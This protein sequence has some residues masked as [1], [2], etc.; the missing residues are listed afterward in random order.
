MCTINSSIQYAND[1][2]F[3]YVVVIFYM[4]YLTVRLHLIYVEV[5][6]DLYKKRLCE[7]KQFIFRISFVT[8]A[9][10]YELF[11]FF[12]FMGLW[13]QTSYLNTPSPSRNFFFI[14]V[15]TQCRNLLE[16]CFCGMYHTIWKLQRG[17]GFLRKIPWGILIYT[18]TGRRWREINHFSSPQKQSGNYPFG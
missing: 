6:K 3:W 4:M 10:T 5:S 16:Y 15:T 13:D 8:A 9:I 12:V 14:T 7:Q 18:V 11:A 1:I 2:R 17:K